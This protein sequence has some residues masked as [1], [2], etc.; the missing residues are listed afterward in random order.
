MSRRKKKKKHFRLDD[1]DLEN[2]FGAHWRINS[3]T[4]RGIAVILLFV[5][6]SLSFLS[7]FD[8]AGDFGRWG[9]SVLA[10][11]FGSLKWLFPVMT[12]LFGYFLLRG[13]KYQIKF[14]NYLGAILLVLGLT[15]LWHLQ[16][17]LKEAAASAQKGLG[18]GM[19]DLILS[20]LFLKL[21]GFWGAVVM[22]LAIFLI[23][24]LL[25]FETSIY[26]LMWPA[27][28]VKYI[29]N[30]F[31]SVYLFLNAGLSKTD[32]KFEAENGAYEEEPEEE[33]AESQES[34]GRLAES[35]AMAAEDIPKFKK[36]SV[37]EYGPENE[38]VPVEPRFKKFGKKI[39]LPLD[40][41]VS[42]SSKPTSGDIRSNQEIIKK[43]LSNFGIPVEMGE[44]N[45]GPTVTQ[46]T[47]RPADGVR[48][49]KIINLNSD[50][51][52]A[53]AAH[54]IRIE[55]PIPGKSLVGIEIPNQM[56]ARVTMFEML[57]SQGFKE[58]VDNLYLALGKDVSGKPYFSRLERMPHLL[59]AG[60]TG[61]G[62]SVCINALIVSLLYQN[63]PDELKFILVDPKRVE[64]PIY[65]NIPYLLTPVI[66][67]I[68]KTINALKW[69]IVEMERRFELLSRRGKRNIEMYNRDGA[70][71][72]PYIIFIIDELA[73]LMSAAGADIE[74]GIV[75]LAQMSRAVGIH[76]I[77]ATQRPSVEVVT[78]L[79]KANIPTRTAFS[80]ASLIDSR[81]ILD[82]SGAEKLVGRG[83]MLFLGPGVA[84]PK[85]LQGVF[86]SDREISNIINYIKQQGGAQYIDGVIARQASGFSP[87]GGDYYSAD[88]GDSLLGEA[89][90]I[91][92]Q[93]GKASA[94]LLQRR[95]KIGY[96]RAARI[97][98]LLEEQAVIG[99]ADGAKPREVFLD[100][101]D[102]VD[103]VVAF[104]AKEYDLEGELAPAYR[105]GRPESPTVFKH[106]SF[107][108]E[109]LDNEAVE[110]NGVAEDIS[111]PEEEAQENLEAAEEV[112]EEDDNSVDDE[113]DEIEEKIEKVEKEAEQEEKEK[114]KF[115]QQFDEDEWT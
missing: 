81:T 83:D 45:I 70:D 25:T 5:F 107:D 90:E 78:G 37:N 94:S 47:L 22:C 38:P 61:S 105:T 110:D 36:I 41:L 4:K 76:L 49:A 95:L 34:E 9:V 68:K 79:I 29:F 39:E 48:L 93:A 44:V 111:E 66:T 88:E 109:N 57:T 92:R 98:D 7:I 106:E 8:L 12:I 16:F 3:E 24:L 59:I 27:R 20:F 67:D 89:K 80:V 19:S 31:K 97:L 51:A 13:E 46:Y 114:K 86:L 52:L 14:V 28:L 53:L 73:D 108:S 99:P 104:A 2:R 33:M 23:G 74:A 71:K 15:A 85:R 65:N 60:A 62:K 82:C 18:G 84:K 91:I 64:L 50:L 1:F 6:G 30:I 40:L 77:L 26:G 69:T 21:M 112:S 35:D 103:D 42:K 113:A 63:S 55:A 102:G 115:K 43:T 101:L 32:S 100:R 87:Y 10:I 56:A 17:D 72:M 11:L 75:R 58:R 54:P 96:A